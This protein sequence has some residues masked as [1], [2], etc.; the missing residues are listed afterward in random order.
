MEEKLCHAFSPLCEGVNM[1]QVLAY[2][3]IKLS[4]YSIFVLL[5]F[6]FTTIQLHTYWKN[7]KGNL[8][9]TLLYYYYGM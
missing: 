6:S 9:L 8:Y 5:R 7:P 3:I 2:I 1:M 4:H